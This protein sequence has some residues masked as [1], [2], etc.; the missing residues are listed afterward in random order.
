M[1]IG[2]L[3]SYGPNVPEFLRQASTY[4]GKIL[5]GARP[6][7]L[8]MQQPTTFELTIN[9]KR[10]KELGLVVP[11]TVIARAE[12]DRMRLATSNIGMRTDLPA[13]PLFG[14]CWGKSRHGPD[15]AN[16]T[17]NPYSDI[18]QHLMLQ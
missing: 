8:P 3:L 4:V 5:K 16:D 9:L 10:A 1:E 12:S 17:N 11:P 13:C 2:A 14:R 15:T 18:G 6:A 7:D